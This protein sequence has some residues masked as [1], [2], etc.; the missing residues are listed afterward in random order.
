M[1]AAERY[2]CPP[3]EADGPYRYFKII[4]TIP[5]RV[6]CVGANFMGAEST[7]AEN[8]GALKI[9]HTKLNRIEKDELDV[10]E[11]TKQEFIDMCRRDQIRYRDTA[12]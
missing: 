12:K 7:D 4:D 6:T 5:V 11:I 1:M 2:I 10:E 8:G 3:P 9:A